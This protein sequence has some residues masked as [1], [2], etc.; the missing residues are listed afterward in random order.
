MDTSGMGVG[1]WPRQVLGW[2]D[3]H[4]MY[5]SGLSTSCIGVGCPRHVLE[6][7]VHVMYRS[8]LSTSCIGVGCPRQTGRLLYMQIL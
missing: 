8:G 5:W 3:V 6:W 1:G 2:V 4:V 7:V